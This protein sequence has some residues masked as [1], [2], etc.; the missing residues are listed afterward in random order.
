MT[1]KVSV[2]RA[3]DKISTKISKN[4]DNLYIGGGIVLGIGS[5]ISAVVNT[6][7]A[8][9]II[10]DH[11]AKMEEIHSEMDNDLDALKTTEH[12]DDDYS[13]LKKEHAR[14][15]MKEYAIFAG[16]MAL[17]YLP[18]IGLGTAAG[19][20][21][22]K[23]VGKLKEENAGLIYAYGVLDRGF[24]RYRKN[25]IDELG[26]EADKRFRFGIKEDIED[27]ETVD[28]KGNVKVKK[29]KVNKISDETGKEY[30]DYARYFD[31]SCSEWTKNPEYNLCYVKA[32]EKIANNMLR[33]RGHLFLNEVY[34]MLG[35]PRTEYGQ[36]VGW[37]YDEKNPIGDNYV[38]FGIYDLRSEATRRFVNG[39]ENVILLDFNVDGVISD[40]I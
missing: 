1:F 10:E 31:S 3:F 16:R 8:T 33:A 27:V 34:D 25:V 12:T 29:E 28:K 2:P 19:Y 30:S 26:A 36:Y 11:K 22:L 15:L 4:S 13:E 35:I 24:K 32:Q 17:N 38:D 40:K 21:V 18:T 9:D 14:F 5:L 7:K 20:C 39:L 37:I 6:F 23:G